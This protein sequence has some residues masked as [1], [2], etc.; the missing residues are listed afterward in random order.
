MLQEAKKNNL[1][2]L[3]LSAMIILII[4]KQDVLASFF[5]E[6]KV[7]SART[8]LKSAF[9]FGG[10]MPSGIYKHSLH[11][12]EWKK[13]MSEKM[14]G[15]IFSEETKRK[16]SE[17]N[18]GQI[19]WNKGRKLSEKHKKKIGSGNK[20]KIRSQ[21]TIIKLSESHRGKKLSQ[22]TKNKLKIITRNRMNSYEAR[23]QISDSLKGKKG[24]GWKGG[25]NPLNDTLRKSV[26][27]TFWRKSV[28]ERDKYICRICNQNSRTLRAHHIWEFAKFP[29]LRFAINNGLTLCNECHKKIHK[30]GGINVIKRSKERNGIC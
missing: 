17:A 2:F 12:A 27:Y 22:E 14:K 15:R 13:K 6:P 10:I 7:E 26:E 4:N 11:S 24:S 18:K 25:I 19:P 5:I 30:K 29:E 23:K 21:E 9:C 16:T 8:L 1:T 20:N 3:F 28:F